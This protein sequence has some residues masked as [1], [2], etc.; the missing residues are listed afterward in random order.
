MRGS[1]RS[2]VLVVLFLLSGF[3]LAAAQPSAAAA[4]AKKAWTVMLYLNGDNNLDFEGWWTMD[5][6]AAGLKASGSNVNVVV[7]YDHYGPGGAEK[8]LIT[9]GKYTKIGTVAEPDMGSPAALQSFVTWAMKAYPADKYILDLWDHGGGWMYMS[10]DDTSHSR[11]Y[12][13]DIGNAMAAAEKTVGDVVD[14]TLFEACT[15]A[16][17]EVA[18]QLKGV[19]KVELGTEVTMDAEG[20]PW[21]WICA[22]MEADPSIA[23]LALGKIIADD[24]VLYYETKKQDGGNGN[25]DVIGTFSSID[26]SK[27]VALAKAVDQLSLALI[28]K[29][30][31]YKSQLGSA[32]SYAKNQCFESIMG[33]FWFSDAW[34]LCNEL[35]KSIDDPLIDYWAGQVKAQIKD[36]S[37]CATSHQQDTRS[38]GMTLAFPPNAPHYYDNYYGRVYDDIG[39]FFPQDTHWDEMLRAYYVASGN[40]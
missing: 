21:N 12:V 29:M 14:M 17:A 24:Y 36:G 35:Q 31:L 9:A 33:V 10:R 5:L 30:G 8:Y 16:Q 18:Y 7:L 22:S 38:Y 39:L 4:P 26:E 11:M 19:T 3:L 34:A 2:A 27:Q 40:K 15:M 28:A 23:P 13:A 6:M 37:Y 20:P 32:A 25:G 1:R